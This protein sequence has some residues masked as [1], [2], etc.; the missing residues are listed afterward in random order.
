MII[1]Y[2]IKPIDLREKL[3]RFWDLSGEKI[4]AIES[5]Y[6]TTRGCTGFYPRRK[7]YHPR[8]DGM[9]P[10]FPVWIGHPAVRRN[11]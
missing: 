11:R 3:N 10:G 2:H 9:D 7:I 6:D 8:L 5:E 1:D 4:K